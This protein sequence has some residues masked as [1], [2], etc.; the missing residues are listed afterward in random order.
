MSYC[1][2]N[3]LAPE[4]PEARRPA[5]PFVW[6]ARAHLCDREARARPVFGPTLPALGFV[7]SVLHACTQCMP[8]VTC[9]RPS[10][11]TA[12]S[13]RWPCIVCAHSCKTISK[14]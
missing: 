9:P 12:E 5:P 14:T 4:V 8:L 6:C 13:L 3:D 10:P 11:V 7:E 1:V 2:Y